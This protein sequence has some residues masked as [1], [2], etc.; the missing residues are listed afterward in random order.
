MKFEE[1]K[2]KIYEDYLDIIRPYLRDMI[3]NH[4][5]PIKNPNGIIIEDD[6]SGEWKI[7]IT[8]QMSFVSSLDTREMCTMDSK[9]D[10]VEITMSN[11]TDNIIKEIFESFKKDIKKD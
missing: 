8:M 1:T 5:V 9:S 2:I 11:E 6:L 4:K 10:K 7:Q 3:N